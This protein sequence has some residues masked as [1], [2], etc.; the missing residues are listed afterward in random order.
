MKRLCVLLAVLALGLT[1][2]AAQA[3]S[4]KAP[5]S[6]ATQSCLE[7]HVEATPGIVDDWKRGRMSRTSVAQA[8]KKEALKRRVSAK[9]VPAEMLNVAVGCAECHTTNPK[10][11]QDTFEH[12]DAQVHTV[13]TPQDCAVCHPEEANQYKG[14][15]MSH[16]WGNLV[17]NPVYMNLVEQINGVQEVIDGAKITVQK[18]G[19]LTNAE[20]CLY[21]HGTEVKVIG[22]KTREVGDYGEMSFPQLSG[23]PNHGVGRINPDGS[24]GSCTP[25]HSRHQFSIAMAR[26]PQTCSECHKGPDVPA[27]KVYQVSKHGNI[28]AALNQ[29]WNMEAVPWKLGQDFNAPTCATCHVSLLTD[30]QGN[31]IA[32]RTHEMADRIWWRLIGL[33]Y[34]HPHPISPDTSIIKNADGL[35]LATT[36][37]GKPASKYLIGP[38]EQKARQKRMAKVCLGCH[39]TQWVTGQMARFKNS[40]QTADAMVLAATKL[41]QQIWAKGWAKG[42]AQGASPF[43]EYIERIW[44]DQW[45]LQ[46]NAT[47]MATAMMGVDMGVFDQGRWYTSKNVRRM[48]DWIK[49]QEGKK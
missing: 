35:P 29:T 48:H 33:I 34:S 31:V 24:K 30:S 17:K 2:T 12:G 45:L 4:D 15:L 46:A 49:R 23:W 16:A 9:E 26:S 44:V 27:Y 47:R 38:K 28:Y 14:N 19:P 20:S 25:C 39:S 40:N 41:M 7:C 37:D 13:V 32:K 42:L 43:D 21:C 5:L 18:P 3:A 22:M 11:H 36:F 1:A 10:T 8:L 6:E